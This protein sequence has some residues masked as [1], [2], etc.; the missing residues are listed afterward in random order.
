MSGWYQTHSLTESL[1]RI[2]FSFLE[3][4]FVSQICLVIFDILL[5]FL[6]VLRS[7]FLSEI[8]WSLSVVYP[9]L[10][11]S[12]VCDLW[13][14]HASVCFC[15]AH[16]RQL[17]PLHVSWYLLVNSVTEASVKTLWNL[18]L[19]FGFLEEALQLLLPHVDPGYWPPRAFHSECLGLGEQTEEYNFWSQTVSEGLR[20]LREVFFPPLPSPGCSF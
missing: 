12:N 16:W 19:Q 20:I 2:L 5:F 13:G 17:A 8:M 11:T 14:F 9:V 6:N 7:Y 1:I 18:D 4:I 15:S 3:F 10:D